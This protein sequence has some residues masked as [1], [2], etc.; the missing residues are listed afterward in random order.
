M[1]KLDR[2]GLAN[3]DC[4]RERGA[5]LAA[6]E[7]RR[8]APRAL[9]GQRHAEERARVRRGLP[10]PRGGDCGHRQTIQRV[11]TGAGEEHRGLDR[12]RDWDPRGGARRGPVRR[13]RGAGR[14][15]EPA[16]QH[17]PEDRVRE[18]LRDGA[19]RDLQGGAERHRQSGPQRAPR[20][21]D[22]GL[23]GLREVPPSHPQVRHH[24]ERD[25]VVPALRA[26]G[27]VQLS[28]VHS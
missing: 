25:Q 12:V 16:P 22:P 28:C 13:V 18:G 14:G 26:R 6:G 2:F 24:Q 9:E 1:L 27:R 7:G 19:V 20:E 8:G 4:E 23:L 11:W 5:E 17:G 15:E 3:G 21:G 10:P